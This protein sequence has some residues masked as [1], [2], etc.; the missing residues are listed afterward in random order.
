MEIDTHKRNPILA[1]IPDSQ[2]HHDLNVS[3]FFAKVKKYV[4]LENI[5]PELAI[6]LKVL[7]DCENPYYK[8]SSQL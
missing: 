4:E 1:V 8:Q 5:E 7:A 2:I 3:E 6:M